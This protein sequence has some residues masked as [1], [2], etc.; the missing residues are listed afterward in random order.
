MNN[1]LIV[2]AG[3]HGKV[4]VESVTKMKQWDKI[5]FLDD[6]YTEGSQCN[7]YPILGRLD[8]YIEFQNDYEDLFVAIGDN[9]LRLDY[10]KKFSKVGFNIPNVIHPSAIISKKAKI[11]KGIAIMA[12]AVVNSSAIIG[13]GTII[14]TLAS[15]D[16]DC[17]LYEGVHI[18]PGVSL[19]GSVS[20]GKL[21]WIGIG[22]SI[23][24]G[25]NIG[26][27]VVVGAGAVVIDDVSKKRVV[28]GNPAKPI[29]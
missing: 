23:I 17:R 18:C 19:A 14:N 26:E 1:L 25:I 12:N 15:V 27:E 4:V 29:K 2:G 5:A 7:D 8:S 21:S 9:K 24:E 11:E 20:I 13:N 28:A 6:A 3:G 16:H 10:M 22:S